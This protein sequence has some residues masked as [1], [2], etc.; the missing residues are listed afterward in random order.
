MLLRMLPRFTKRQLSCFLFLMIL[1]VFKNIFSA[2][3][4]GN[5]IGA[6]HLKPVLITVRV[7]EQSVQGIFRCY[8]D[9]KKK[10]WVD[11]NELHAWGLNTLPQQPME[12]DGQRYYELDWYQGLKYI[13]DSYALQLMVT[14]PPEWLPATK[15][16]SQTLP[17]NGAI[18][19]KNP[20]IF[21]NYDVTG[22]HNALAKQSYTAGTTELGY[23][24]PMG[25]GTSTFLWNG[26]PQNTNTQGL[27]RLE[28]TWTLDK[29]EKIATWRL[30]DSIT[31]TVD[32]SG[33]TRFAGI[34]YATNFNTQPNLVTF[35]LP[36]FRGKAV[37]PSTVDV[38]VNNAM[39]QQ[40]QIKSGPFY[41]NDI[42]VV[43]GAGTMRV[44]T[45][46]FLGRQQISILPYYASEQLLKPGLPNFSYE[47]GATR[48]N[49]GVRSNEYGEPLI[50]ASY[51]FGITSS[52]TIGGHVEV[53]PEEQTAGFINHSLLGHLGILTIGGAASESSSGMGGLMEVAFRRQ[54]PQ[55]SF[56]ERVVVTSSKYQQIGLLN[57]EQP[58]S[59]TGQAFISYSSFRRGSVSLSYTEL[60]NRKNQ[61][62]ESEVFALL[63]PNSRL[64]TFNYSQTFFKN[65]YFLVGVL[66]DFNH[67]ENNQIF[68]S[69]VWAI[70]KSKSMSVNGVHQQNNDQANFEINKNLPLGN[71][72]GYRFVAGSRSVSRYEGDFAWNNTYSTLSAKYA[73]VQNTN[74]YQ[75]NATGSVL[76]FGGA[77]LLTRAT[78]NSFALVQVPRFKNVR[79][80]YRN[81]LIGKTNEKGNLYIPRL[82]PYQ[83][84]DIRIEPTD[85]PL[86]TL[87]EEVDKRSVP[88]YR[89]GILVRFPVHLIQNAMISLYQKNGKPVPAGADVIL[90]GTS[91]EMKY[92]VGYDGKVFLYSLNSKHVNA[93]AVWGNYRCGFSFEIPTVKN[94]I[95][96]VGKV[97]CH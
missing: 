76:H 32:W 59:V 37:L 25:I 24:N 66:R 49:Y 65:L 79:V 63:T 9:D 93:M 21:L 11:D 7:N 69:L 67:H 61:I 74:N 34:Q 77:T 71:G 28:T 1:L 57:H 5:T 75:L 72:Y 62:S 70:G 4:V 20:G 48:L 95:A 27:T 8:V 23:F 13:F 29:P 35:P 14:V 53:L 41:V 91:S 43:I 86:N 88:Y 31:S 19:P 22:Q 81:L 56:G 26:Q 82:L 40:Q 44:V 68:S 51:A 55:W 39:R 92:P 17:L 80:Y 36:V 12:Y 50:S 3:P 15:V 83:E 90:S 97:I 78:E 94:G 89:S 10:I 16:S 46:D 42:P 38:F 85:L 33:A 2:I 60:K 84:N 47:V 58:P 54:S 87:I 30:G 18:R 73:N 52:D 6:L 64:L 96:N 45:E